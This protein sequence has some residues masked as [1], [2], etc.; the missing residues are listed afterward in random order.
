[1]LVAGDVLNR[2]R[3]FLFL[4]TD[5]ANL[6]ISDEEGLIWLTL[7]QREVARRKPDS[8]YRDDKIVTTL[9]VNV[10]SLTQELEVLDQYE[11]ALINYLMHKFYAKDSEDAN[12]RSRMGDHHRMFISDLGV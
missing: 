1:M 11:N 6:R 7:G 12:N 2:A 8:M 5:D 9:P 3:E 4:D 10:S